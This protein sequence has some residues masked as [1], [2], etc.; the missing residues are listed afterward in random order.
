MHCRVWVGQ[1]SLVFGPAFEV[2]SFLHTSCCVCLHVRVV[3][4]TVLT[5]MWKTWVCLGGVGSVSECQRRCVATTQAHLSSSLLVAW[6]DWHNN[7][8]DV[9]QQQDMLATEVTC[10][11]DTTSNPEQGPK[12]QQ[13]QPQH[14]ENWPVLSAC[15]RSFLDASCSHIPIFVLL[16]VV[17]HTSTCHMLCKQP[18]GAPTRLPVTPLPC[19]ACNPQALQQAA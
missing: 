18:Q 9:Q 12:Q 1:D 16:L 17:R 2:A 6:A 8:L 7:S 19:Q 13:Q 5:Q 11:F 15:L 10:K 14:T 3:M 4:I